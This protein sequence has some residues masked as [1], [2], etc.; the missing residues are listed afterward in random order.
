MRAE[1]NK[2]GQIANGRELGLSEQLDGDRAFELRKIDFHA[3]HKA[4]QIG[5]G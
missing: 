5:D 1:G 4:R 2:V 3:L